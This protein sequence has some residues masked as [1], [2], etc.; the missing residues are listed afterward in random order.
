LSVRPAV[1]RWPSDSKKPSEKSLAGSTNWRITRVLGPRVVRVHVVAFAR[2]LES[3]PRCE[4]DRPP[5]ELGRRLAGLHEEALAEVHVHVRRRPT[6]ARLDDAPQLEDSVMAGNPQH[7]EAGAGLR[8]REASADLKHER[9]LWG[10]ITPAQVTAWCDSRT[11]SRSRS[12]A[13][14]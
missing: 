14:R 4:L 2:D 9:R 1:I 12:R 11:R 7:L 13:S 10:T 6:G 8:V 3:V 5:L